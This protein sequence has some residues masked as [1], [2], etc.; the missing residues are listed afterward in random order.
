MPL[1]IAA[2]AMALLR[3][4]PINAE[5]ATEI[6]TADGS[7]EQMAAPYY[8]EY[9]YTGGH[10]VNSSDGFVF[11]GQMYVERLI[12]AVPTDQLLPPII[13]IHTI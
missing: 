3:L 11:R 7:A 8:R 4:A 10:Y 1:W 6:G 9:Y 12:P 2:F 5:A 13:I